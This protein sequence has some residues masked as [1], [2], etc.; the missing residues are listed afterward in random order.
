MRE[1]AMNRLARLRSQRKEK[2]AAMRALIDGA[3]AD[4]EGRDLTAEEQAEY[5][6]L[7]AEVDGLDAQITRLTSLDEL[8]AS[9]REVNPAAARGQSGG[10]ATG[11]TAAGQGRNVHAPGPEAAREFESFGEF[12][13]A[14]RFNTND[15]RLAS[16][17]DENAGANAVDMSA[18]QRMDTG[19]AGGFMVPTQFRSEI[20]RV[21]PGASIVRP[22]ARVIPAGSPPDAAISIPALDQDGAA[23]SNIFGGVT[24]DWIAEGEEKPE[25]EAKLREIKL[26][27]HE[28]AGHVVITDKLLRNWQAAGSFVSDLF[29]GAIRQAE[30]FAFIRGT[31]AGQP[32]GYLN[33]TALIRVPREGAGAVSYVDLVNMLARLLM[34]GGSPVWTASQSV[35]PQILNMRDEE[36]RLI[37]QTNIRE[38]VG[39]TLLGYPLVWNNRAA[40]LGSDGDIT[41]ADFSHY[42]IKDGSGPFVAASEHVLFTQNKTVIKVFWNVDGQPW[43]RQP[44]TEE[45]GYQVSPFVALGL[46]G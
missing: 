4:G 8:E 1:T 33:S 12:L 6:G 39:Q 46:P 11:A 20:L 43:L 14:V 2:I 41:L 26:E 10:A 30:D 22:R 19:S 13:A 17:Y 35:L 37:Y 28:V 42:L 25:T 29:Q 3:A 40:G 24:V 16:L 27:P 15:Q 32:L 31:G 18:E 45:N 9:D 5:D 34:R 44:F 7:K 23:P 36:G 21:E 38:G